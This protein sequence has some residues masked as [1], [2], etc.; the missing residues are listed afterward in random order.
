MINFERAEKP[1]GKRGLRGDVFLI[2]G[3]PYMMSYCGPKMMLIAFDGM[4]WDDVDFDAKSSVKDVIEKLT[5]IGED[6]FHVAAEVEYIGPC[7]VC[8]KQR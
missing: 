8:I 5:E 6:D 4:Y 7:D 3:E 1:E 2:D